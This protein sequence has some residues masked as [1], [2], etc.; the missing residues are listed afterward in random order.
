MKCFCSCRFLCGLWIDLFGEVANIHLSTD[1]KNLVTT[2]RTIHLPEERESI[3]VISLL[4]KEACSGTT[5]DLDHVPATKCLDR[6]I[7][8]C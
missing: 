4:Q 2:A 6:K 7:A 1:G 5:H 3:H 8:S